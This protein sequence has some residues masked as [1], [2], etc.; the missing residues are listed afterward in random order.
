MKNFLLAILFIAGISYFFIPYDTQV[1][2]LEKV[3]IDSSF[4][5]VQEEIEKE[6][7]GGA[8]NLKFDDNHKVSYTGNISSGKIME[9]LSW[10]SKPLVKCFDSSKNDNFN[11]NVV[12]HRVLLGKNKTANVKLISENNESNL[13]MY[14]YKTDSL[15]KV[16]PPE[17]EYT[18]DCKINITKDI[19]KEIEMKGNTITSDIVIGI[20]G[21]NG[22]LEGGYTLE[23]IEK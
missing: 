12:L 20:S 1:N 23:I 15:S 13:T 11:G 22:I 21:S 19:S 7:K 3:G 9:D 8:I 16:F 18:H 14:V 5:P 10:A 4:L 17:K 6:N 2:L